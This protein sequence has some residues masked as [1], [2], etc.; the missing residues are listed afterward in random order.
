MIQRIQSLFLFLGGGLM[1]AVLGFP[2]ATTGSAIAGSAYFN[3]A[4]FNV[5]DNVALLV[6]YGLSGV[7]ALAAIFLFRNRRLQMRMAI[8]SAIMGVLA[9]GLTILFFW[10]D[11]KALESL[12]LVRNGIS[13]YLPVLGLILLFLAY[14]YIGKDE[15]LVRSMDRL[16]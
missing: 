13:A 11:S 6:V 2:F 4:V 15:K 3:D 1:L 10:Q 12:A 5:R 9:I 8:S 16:R 14:R 7:L